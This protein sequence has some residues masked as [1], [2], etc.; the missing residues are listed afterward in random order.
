MNTGTI[1]TLPTARNQHG[2]LANMM[3]APNN[4]GSEAE[5]AEEPPK[6][7]PKRAAKG[8]KKENA[9]PKQKKARLK[10]GTLEGGKLDSSEDEDDGGKKKNPAKRPVLEDKVGSCLGW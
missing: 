3:M 9:A 6:A 7:K 5:T 4:A 10:Q 1:T 8:S 2:T